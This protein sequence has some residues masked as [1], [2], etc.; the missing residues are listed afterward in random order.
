MR[1]KKMDLCLNCTCGGKLGW[2]WD[3]LMSSGEEISTQVLVK[4]MK[5]KFQVL[6]I[7]KATS[8]LCQMWGSVVYECSQTHKAVE[9]LGWLEYNLRCTGVISSCSTSQELNKLLKEINLLWSEVSVYN[10]ISCCNI[11]L[12]YQDM[13]NTSLSLMPVYFKISL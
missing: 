5:P 3:L 8:L 11:Y 13:H 9:E 2:N 4:N 7:N 12:N 10:L 6:Q 1:M